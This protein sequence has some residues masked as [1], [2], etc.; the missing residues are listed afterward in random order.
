MKLAI[1]KCLSECKQISFVFSGGFDKDGL[2]GVYCCPSCRSKDVANLITPKEIEKFKE[3]MEYI[4]ITEGEINKTAELALKSRWRQEIP[5]GQLLCD[6]FRDHES[7]QGASEK[8]P[9][10]SNMQ[11]LSLGTKASYEKECLKSLGLSGG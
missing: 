1:V 4:G 2:K 7:G 8:P 5:V 11:Q 3:V 9:E 6:R 10:S